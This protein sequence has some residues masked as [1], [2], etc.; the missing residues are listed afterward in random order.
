MSS[1]SRGAKFF[2]GSTVTNG[3]GDWQGMDGYSSGGH[4]VQRT[5]ERET[6][7]VET[8]RLDD[9]VDGPVRF[10]KIDVQG[11]EFSVLKGA[12]ELFNHGIELALIEFQG[13]ARIVQ[14][15][16]ERGYALLDT[17]YHTTRGTFDLER[18]R[19]LGSVTLSSGRQ[20]QT[21]V[22]LNAPGDPDSYAAWFRE[23]RKHYG[24][25]WTDLIAI[26]PSSEL[27]RPRSVLLRSLDWLRA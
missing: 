3:T 23:E 25:L 2:V 12:Q 27:L 4:I 15:L 13:D 14:F 26:A 7:H 5:D 18:W 10:L 19:L 1:H 8:C 6:L 21:A 17:D 20:A 9:V 24:S 16:A 11:H 22:P